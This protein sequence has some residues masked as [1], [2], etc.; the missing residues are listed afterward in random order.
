MIEGYVTAGSSSGLNYNVSCDTKVTRFQ[1]TPCY[2]HSFAEK[3]SVSVM[4]SSPALKHLILKL[5]TSFYM[6]NKLESSSF[7]L[8]NT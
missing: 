1:Y 3:K 5:L 7:N 2:E 4:F 8:M 6:H